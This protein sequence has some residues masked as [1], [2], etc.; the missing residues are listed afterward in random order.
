M[1]PPIDT[2]TCFCSSP[3]NSPLRK[4]PQSLHSAVRHND[5]LD[6]GERLVLY[7]ALDRVLMIRAAL[8]RFGHLCPALSIRTRLAFALPLDG[9]QLDL[10]GVVATEVSRVD[11]EVLDVAGRAESDNGPVDV[12]LGARTCCL[13]T[14]THVLAAARKDK[15]VLGAEVLVTAGDGNSAVLGS[16]Q[17]KDGLGILW[18]YRYGVSK[19]TE[20]GN[21]AV[22]VHV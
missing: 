17:V 13:P 12:A 22:R 9:L 6:V 16:R 7:Q 20:S 3:L 1:L 21:A 2:I 4:H 18:E 8:D 11:N 15:V 10:L 14:V 19:Q 5:E